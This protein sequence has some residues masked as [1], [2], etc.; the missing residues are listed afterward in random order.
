MPSVTLFSRPAPTALEV[1][2]LNTAS[3]AIV[4]AHPISVSDQLFSACIAVAPS[5]KSCTQNCGLQELYFFDDT[6]SILHE[7]PNPPAQQV[8]KLAYEISDNDN[9]IILEE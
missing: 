4:C 7:Q 8:A 3:C 1:Q 9:T 6:G 2:F 5:C